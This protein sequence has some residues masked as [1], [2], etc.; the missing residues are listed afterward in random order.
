MFNVTVFSTSLSFGLHQLTKLDGCELRLPQIT[1]LR[2]T[3]N[4]HY[5]A[6]EDA[7]PV[8]KFFPNLTYLWWRSGIPSAVA[9]LPLTELR[10]E[11]SFFPCW[12]YL[13]DTYGFF[14]RNLDVIS[15]ATQLRKLAFNGQGFAR[16]PSSLPNLEEL[17]LDGVPNKNDDIL[18]SFPDVRVLHLSWSA[19]DGVTQANPKFLA[20]SLVQHLRLDLASCGAYKFNEPV[21]VTCPILAE[22][23]NNT[24]FLP[25]L[26]IAEIAVRKIDTEF[27]SQ[28]TLLRQARP[29]VRVDVSERAP[30]M[31]IFSFE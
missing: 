31:R 29:S 17:S 20:F 12:P 27:W 26:Q 21:C 14:I 30:W 7:E 22:L 2:V 9:T 19:V 28:L 23:I 4:S 24:E 1:R 18:R 25:G 8:L 13:T 15:Q 6:L 11:L 16:L 3:W 10:T 5:V